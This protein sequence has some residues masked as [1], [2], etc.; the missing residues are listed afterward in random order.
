MRNDFESGY[1]AHHGILGQKHGQRN[2]PPYPLDADDHSAAEKKA[3][4]H[5][6][7]AKSIKDH[8]IAKKRKKALNKARKVRAQ[9]VKEQKK[10]AKLA[11]KQLHEEKK[12]AKEKDR[13]LKSGDAKEILKYK[14]KLSDQELK[15]ALDR[16]RNDIALREIAAKSEKSGFDRIDDIMNTAG[17]V[18]DW[19]QK[20]VKGYNTFAE[21]YNSVKAH[22]KE[23]QLPI[24]GKDNIW[25]QRQNEKEKKQLD[26]E[27]DLID[28]A[29]KD[30][31]IKQKN[32][33]TE[34]LA[35]QKNEHESQMAKQERE[36]IEQLLKDGYPNVKINWDKK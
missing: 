18:T 3:G 31:V 11:K 8:R 34:Q 9:H 1:L 33:F 29:Y 12:F 26:R 23:E 19:A 16:V 5:K 35:K 17:K 4:W 32:D 36:W 28:K 24:I 15:N 22:S 6:S 21:I 7:L 14:D 10:E 25:V 27:K 20:G 30:K 13:I 2:G